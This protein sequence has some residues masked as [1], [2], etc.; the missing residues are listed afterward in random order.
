VSQGGLQICFN[1]ET[2]QLVVRQAA[3]MGAVEQDIALS[4]RQQVAQVAA[5]DRAQPRA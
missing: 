1:G 4:E 3:V 2:C 5:T